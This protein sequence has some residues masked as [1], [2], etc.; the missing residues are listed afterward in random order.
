MVTSP[1][2]VQSNA[3]FDFVCNYGIM[4]ITTDFLSFCRTQ[5]LVEHYFLFISED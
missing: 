5:A 3:I 2:T 4:C 1:D